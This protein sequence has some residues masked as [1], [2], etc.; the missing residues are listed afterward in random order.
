MGDL[1][2]L[3]GWQREANRHI[4]ARDP[5]TGKR[6][7]RIY[8]YGTG[9]KNGKTTCPGA[10]VAIY[11]LTM[12]AEGGEV[13][14]L[15]NDRDQARYLFGIARRMVELD[16]ELSEEIKLYRDAMEHSASGS[17]YRVLSAESYS[18]EGF[19][20]TLVLYDELHAAPTRDLF[21]V[22][23]LAM[24][25]R[26]EPLMLIPTTAGVMSTR[27]ED[28][29]IC[30]QL[31]Q[32]GIKVATGQIIDPTFGMAW[33]EPPPEADHRDEKV[34]PLGNPGLGDIVGLDD[35]RSAI[36]RT[37]ESEFRTKRLNMFVPTED[38]WLPAGSWEACK[39]PRF[40]WRQDDHDLETLSHLDG[41][42]R[43]LPIAVGIDVGLHNDNTAVVCAQRQGDKV[44]LRTRVWANPHPRDSA[45]FDS[46]YLPLDEV[47]AYLRR[48][49]TEFPES[50]AR[51]EGRRV[52]GPAF[53]YDR[54]GLAS[55]ELA[56][57]G[58]R[59]YALIPINQ[60]GGWMVAASRL[61]YEQVQTV[62]IQHDGDPTLAAHLRHVVPR[63]VS[64][65][66]WR[67][68]KASDSKKI[69]AAVAAVMATAQALEEAPRP[70]RRAFLA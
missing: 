45:A 53:V 44:Q 7:H 51:I 40:T 56:L 70:E 3:R 50:A 57:E 18:K 16:P 39:D 63:Q 35:M 65:S 43:K 5:L 34:W 17:V 46:W 28:E 1:I 24:G 37:P 23:S 67:L 22:F 38:F 64:E 29:S 14:S 66:G 27:T 62:G 19:S 15:A 6:L 20:P 55:T 32:Y 8:L 52:P 47:V 41:L 58:E 42:D 13:Y 68:E 26:P 36:K 48:L 2:H 4:F 21:D 59:G 30:Y 12:E 11:G 60:Q 10:G 9:R 33:W 69:D 25:S 31:Y 54:Y 49:R 61:F